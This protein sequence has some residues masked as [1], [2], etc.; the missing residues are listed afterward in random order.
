[1]SP[2]RRSRKP[3]NHHGILPVDKPAG[4]TSHDV[5]DVVRGIAG[6]RQVGHTGTLDPAAT[7]LLVLCLGEATKLAE[8]F[9]RMAKVYTGEMVLGA[10]SDTLDRDGE[11]REVKGAVAPEEERLRGATEGFLGEIEQV[12]PLHSAKKVGGRRLYEYARA[13]E[14]VEVEA[15]VVSVHRFD[16]TEYA[17]PR[18]SFVVECGSGTYVRRLVHDLGEDLGCGAYL[19][20]LRRV[21]VGSIDI[22]RAATLERL[23]ETAGLLVDSLVPVREAFSDW[24]TANVDEA[25]L[26]LWRQGHAVPTEWVVF[27]DPGR[28]LSWL[29][30]V[31]LTDS[32]G[33]LLGIGRYVPAP[34]SPPPRELS[35]Y[36]GAW[37]QPARQFQHLSH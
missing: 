21:R 26:P 14:D 8:H 33:R 32:A 16:I 10:V 13:G 9:S 15:R 22:E 36:R 4:M 6:Q 19:G 7:G 11:I 3:P 23:R 2:R 5:V 28:S 12:P 18:A 25:G 35:E 27:A 29:D 30:S 17:W 1:M 34:S 24:P 20:S 31:L 37:I